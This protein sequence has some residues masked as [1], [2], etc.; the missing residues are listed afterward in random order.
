MGMGMFRV[1]IV[2]MIEMVCDVLPWQLILSK[3]W[4]D[5]EDCGNL[6][7]FIFIH[8]DFVGE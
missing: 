7:L 6:F 3:W 2:V 4:V 5:G 1:R 8:V